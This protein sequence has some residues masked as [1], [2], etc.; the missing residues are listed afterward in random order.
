M[1]I[2]LVSPGGPRRPV[3]RLNANPLGGISVHEIRSPSIIATEYFARVRAHDSSVV[4]LFHEDAELIGLGTRRQGRE[5]ILEF[6]SGV[7][8]R[9]GP[10]PRL[11]GSLL[12]DGDRVAAEILIELAAGTTI[13]AVDL[14]A[15]EQDLIRSL[16]YF[17]CSD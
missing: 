7:I 2:N 1:A 3:M 10:T 15:I 14:F 17:I 11:I 13:H 6:Y 9:A 8:E 5:S 12:I 16:T 4:D